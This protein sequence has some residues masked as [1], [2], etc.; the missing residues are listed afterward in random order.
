[1]PRAAVGL[2]LVECENDRAVGHV[3]HMPHRPVMKRGDLHQKPFREKK[4]AGAAPEGAAPA[5]MNIEIGRALA[6]PAVAEY[7]FSHSGMTRKKLPPR[8]EATA[9]KTIWWQRPESAAAQVLEAGSGGAGRGNTQDAKP[10]SGYV[11][12]ATGTWG[13]ERI[14]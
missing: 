12:C 8:E 13:Y 5:E 9:V 14:R 10:A 1:M 2:P 4:K 6:N 3:T 11:I 7:R